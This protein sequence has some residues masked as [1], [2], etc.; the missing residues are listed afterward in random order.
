[1]NNA[2]APSQA[3]LENKITDT[4]LEEYREKG[5]FLNALKTS[6][7]ANYGIENAFGLLVEQVF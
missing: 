4:K 6:A 3:D 7:K 5:G 1:M 2:S